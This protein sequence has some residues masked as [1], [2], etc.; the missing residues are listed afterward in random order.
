[1]SLS[2]NASLPAPRIFVHQDLILFGKTSAVVVASLACK[3]FFLP[4]NDSWL[5]HLPYAIAGMAG[6]SACQHAYKAIKFYQ[7]R[8]NLT[9]PA[10]L[11]TVKKNEQ[12]FERAFRA[13]QS[14]R[15]YND[16]FDPRDPQQATEIFRKDFFRSAIGYGTCAGQADMLLKLIKENPTASSSDLLKSLNE[17]S[18]IQVI[19]YRQMMYWVKSRVESLVEA[20][21]TTSRIVPFELREASSLMSKMYQESLSAINKELNPQ[22]ELTTKPFS[23]TQSNKYYLEQLDSY[24][25]VQ[26]HDQR[27][28]QVHVETNARL[29]DGLFRAGHTLFFQCTPG[30][31]RF[32][33][34]IN[35]AEGFYEKY[36]DKE[37]FIEALRSQLIEYVGPEA[38][39]RFANG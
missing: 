26:P 7:K 37:S 29:A 24:L 12:A 33:D 10:L 13:I 3:R 15:S 27:I 34:P 2:L 8:R 17:E 22:G 31:Y 5:G 14:H 9:A 11:L 21:D 1:M 20:F 39:V 6:W 36:S 38:K 19:F 30:C 16:I 23:I 4:T 32:Y 35:P 25:S 28:G 18:R